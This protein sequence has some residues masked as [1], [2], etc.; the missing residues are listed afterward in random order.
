MK[1]CQDILDLFRIGQKYRAIYMTT[2]K[3]LVLL[4]TLNKHK[5]S[6]FG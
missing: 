1:I 2:K 3:V 5:S 4:A 6:T